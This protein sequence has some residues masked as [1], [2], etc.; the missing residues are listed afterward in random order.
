[1]SASTPFRSSSNAW[2]LSHTFLGQSVSVPAIR[3]DSATETEIAISSC[4]RQVTNGNGCS[5]CSPNSFDMNKT[6]TRKS[7]KFVTSVQ[8]E[9]ERRTAMKENQLSVLADRGDVQH[10]DAKQSG[11][12]STSLRPQKTELE[13]YEDN[14]H[15]ED[16]MPAAYFERD[17]TH[18]D[19]SVKLDISVHC[20]NNSAIPFID[21]VS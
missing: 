7:D 19:K 21:E 15:S 2:K 18:V 16:I 12:I 3:Q 10:A 8:N 13:S 1:M 6:S 17:K 9:K 14:S 11:I 20:D 5:P 4:E